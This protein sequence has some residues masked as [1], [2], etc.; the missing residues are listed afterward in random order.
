MTSR[1]DLKYN[2]SIMEEISQAEGMHCTK[3]GEFRV[4]SDFRIRRGKSQQ[5]CKKCYLEYGRRHYQ[6][7]KQYYIDKAK[8][9]NDAHWDRTHRLLWAYLQK[10]PCIDCGNTDPRVLEFDHVRGEKT[11]NVSDLKS[12]RFGWNAILKEI[13]K[14]DVRCAN[15]HR[16]KTYEQLSW[17]ILDAAL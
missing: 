5:P 13:E 16:I 9:Y 8:R 17:R 1:H 11:H 14:C 15:C 2:R 3:C 6:N 7:N 10:H 12:L 4:L